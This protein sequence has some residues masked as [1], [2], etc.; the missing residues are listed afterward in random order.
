[1]FSGRLKKDDT[2]QR[3]NTTDINEINNKGNIKPLLTMNN[4]SNSHSMIV[5]VSVYTN[6]RHVTRCLNDPVS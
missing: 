1:M 2:T 6:Q 3:R 4:L 5:C